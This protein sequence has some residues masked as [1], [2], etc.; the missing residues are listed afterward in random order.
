MDSYAPSRLDNAGL[1]RHYRDMSETQTTFRNTPAG[2]VAIRGNR[3][4]HLL[5]TSV[6]ATTKSRQL[7][8]GYSF[9]RLF[10][11]GRTAGA[12]GPK[13]RYIKVGA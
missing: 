10:R 5:G 13:V 9:D 3:E 2:I 11:A 7:L 4:L 6:A 12:A 1:D 8:A